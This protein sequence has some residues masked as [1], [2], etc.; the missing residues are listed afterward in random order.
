MALFLLGDSLTE[1]Y[2]V[3]P[4]DCFASLLEEGYEAR[5]YGLCGDTTDG[6]LMRLSMILREAAPGD[7]CLILGGANDI[8]MYG[9]GNC[10]RYNIEDMIKKLKEKGVEPV[11]GIYPGIAL[12]D[13]PFYYRGYYDTYFGAA[14]KL[15]LDIEQLADDYGLLLID[16]MKLFADENGIPKKELFMDGVHPNAGG[17]RLMAEEIKRV[18]R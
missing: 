4:E 12:S 2:G 18:L 6:M 7:R 1:G 16:F 8:L 13:D 5:N 9:E 17:H 14:Q 3:M 10:A 15:A 11:L